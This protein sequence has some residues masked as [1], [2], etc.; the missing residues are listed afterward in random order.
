MTMDEFKIVF[1]IIVAVIYLLSRSRKKQPQRPATP[2]DQSENDQSPG[3]ISFEDLLKE[4]QASKRA[5]TPAQPEL[6][7]VRKPAMGQR[8]PVPQDYQDYDDD[9][10]DDEKDLEEVRDD[11]DK[12]KDEIYN[13]YEKAKQEAFVK[14]SLEETV[15]LEDTVVQFGQFKGYTRSEEHSRAREILK[16]FHD[17]EGFKKAFIMSEILKR[18]F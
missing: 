8:E 10:E 9:I 16:E 4:I 17:P 18:K 11:V 12:K 14:P 2:P 7:P 13:V 5:Q 3:P 6:K 1:W 15:K